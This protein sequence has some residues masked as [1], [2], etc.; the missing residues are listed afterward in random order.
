M[1]GNSLWFYLKPY[2]PGLHACPWISLRTFIVRVTVSKQGVDVPRLNLSGRRRAENRA[3]S[4][5]FV[6]DFL[7]EETASIEV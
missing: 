7:T 5:L 2:L 6:G 1:S 4:D 3:N